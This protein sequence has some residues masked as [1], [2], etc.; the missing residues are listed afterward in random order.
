MPLARGIRFLYCHEPVGFREPQ[1]AQDDAVN[2]GEDG[3]GRAD[4]EGEYNEGDGREPRG[5]A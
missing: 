5:R 2:D 1:A 3:R 4:A